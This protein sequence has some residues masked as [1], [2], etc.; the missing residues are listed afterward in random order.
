MKNHVPYVHI[1]STAYLKRKTPVNWRTRRRE[2]I[3]ANIYEQH[4]EK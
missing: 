1:P 4:P 2:K 3:R